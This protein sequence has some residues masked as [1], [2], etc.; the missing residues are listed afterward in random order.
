MTLRVAAAGYL[1]D[2][3]E[4]E[5]LWFAGSL[6]TYKTTGEQTAGG[7]AVAEVSAPKG[8]GSPRHWHHCEDE[9]WYILDG[10]LTFWLGNQELTASAGAFV[11]GPRDVEHGFRVDSAEARFLLLLTPAGFEDFTRAC[12]Y[13]A[14]ALT[15]PT[16]DL[17]QRDTRV[18]AAAARTHGID[19]VETP[20]PPTPK[21]TKS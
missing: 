1:L 15:M 16:P 20:W 13:P 21:E 18:L 10:Q 19:I 11:F 9:A 6:L 14:T 2:A 8:A 7:L 4:G 17:P 5:A 12:G 3:G